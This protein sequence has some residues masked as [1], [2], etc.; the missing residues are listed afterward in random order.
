MYFLGSDSDILSSLPTLNVLSY[1]Y[2]YYLFQ[3]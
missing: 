1:V 3:V 2:K